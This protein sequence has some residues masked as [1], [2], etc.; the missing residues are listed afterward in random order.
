[1]S[2]SPEIA[3]VPNQE[4]INLNMQFLMT[5]QKQ[6]IQNPISAKHQLGMDEETASF[7]K[8]MT[9]ADILK[10][11]ESGISTIQFRF[12]QNSIKH[13]SNFI[14]GD[15]LAITQALLGQGAR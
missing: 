15:N 2:L 6:L 13:L 11:A 8:S 5:A 10:L 1:M 12:T 14:S 9:S 7:L 3:A 4:L